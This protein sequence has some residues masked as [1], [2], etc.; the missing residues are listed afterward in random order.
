MPRTWSA[1]RRALRGATRTYFADARTT[2]SSS[3]SRGRRRRDGA[4][5]F[6]SAT[7]FGRFLA[8]VLFAF[9]LFFV[10]F[11]RGF[12]FFVR[13]VGFVFFRS[14]FFLFR[15]FFRRVFF[16]SRFRLRFLLFGSGVFFLFDVFLVCHQSV[17]G[18]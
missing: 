2:G 15:V 10:G 8:F 17:L 7:R 3:V 5:F 9:G 16:G 1:I 12:L 6:S 18:A 13:A 4:G 11:R 14:R